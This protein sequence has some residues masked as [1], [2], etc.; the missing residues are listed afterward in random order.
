M[1]YGPFLTVEQAAKVLGIGRTLA[2]QL[3]VRYRAT[4]GAEGLPVIEMGSK[5]LVPR[6]ELEALARGPID[7]V[8]FALPSGPV[9]EVAAESEI[10]PPRREP[11]RSNSPKS[12][13]VDQLNLLD[14]DAA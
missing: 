6:A 4:D 9:R 3:T 8:A 2:Y 5:L 14:P 12:H 1:A 13:A 10:V 7:D 11:R